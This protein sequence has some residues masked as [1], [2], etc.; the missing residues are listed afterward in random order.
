MKWGIHIKKMVHFKLLNILTFQRIEIF[1]FLKFHGFKKLLK[2]TKQTVW[3]PFM[4]G[5]QLPQG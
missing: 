4:D 3:P 1:H 2:K 5:V